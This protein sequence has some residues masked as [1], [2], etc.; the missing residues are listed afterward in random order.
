MTVFIRNYGNDVKTELFVLASNLSVGKTCCLLVT[1]HKTHEAAEC[2]DIF[3]AF[4]LSGITSLNL[5]RS[6]KG[7]GNKT[8]LSN[9]LQ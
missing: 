7:N 2:H 1:R 6:D 9:F 4:P 5:A 3:H 8:L